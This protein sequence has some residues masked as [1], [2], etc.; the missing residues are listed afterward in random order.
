M[1]LGLDEMFS[2]RSACE[3]ETEDNAG[4]WYVTFGSNVTMFCDS[5]D[6]IFVSWMRDGV[7]I[8]NGNNFAIIGV[9][10]N[11]NYSCRIWGPECNMELS[12]SVNIKPF[13]KNLV[14]FNVVFVPGKG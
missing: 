11:N 2:I 8:A 14:I 13:S 12:S 10:E 3:M 9:S 7:N 4:F 5:D 1:I 6:A